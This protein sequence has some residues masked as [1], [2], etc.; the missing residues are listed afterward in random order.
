M[1]RLEDDPLTLK[2]VRRILEK[3]GYKVS[4]YTDPL[5]HSGRWAPIHHY[6]L[7]ITDVKV[8]GMDVMDLLV[9]VKTH[10]ATT[11]AILMTGYASIDNAIEAT[12]E[13]VFY[14]LEK[15]F[16]P[17]QLLEMVKKALDRQRVNKASENI[18]REKKQGAD[19]PVII[20]KSPKIR[21][22]E[23]LIHQIAPSNC[24][25]LY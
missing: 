5:G 20:G 10:C 25:V 8:P 11:E 19:L 16:T 23:T 6:H 17:E 18:K 2:R 13:G 1:R 12:W 3:K 15:P 4:S 14:Y 9:D 22:L 7:V 21:E 24:P